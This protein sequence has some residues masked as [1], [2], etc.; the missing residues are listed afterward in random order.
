MFVHVQ[1]HKN[2]EEKL[3]TSQLRLKRKPRKRRLQIQSDN[4]SP[5]T[6]QEEASEHRCHQCHKIYKNYQILRAHQK[7]HLPIEKRKRFECDICH[8]KLTSATGLKYHKE[9][10]HFRVMK[11]KCT[12]CGRQY[13]RTQR[14]LCMY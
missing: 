7:T 9:E 11:Y 10:I 3:E 5:V 1:S 6:E 14:T 13:P 4:G 12:Y 2:E 8:A